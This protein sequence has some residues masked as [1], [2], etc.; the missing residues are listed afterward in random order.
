[1]R[2]GLLLEEFNLPAES[3]IQTTRLRLIPGTSMLWHAERED[4]SR[5]AELLG[6]RVPETWPPPIVPDPSDGGWWS[7]YFLARESSA[8]EWVLI[9]LAGLKGWPSVNESVQMG[10]SFLPEFRDMGYGT[11]GVGALTRWALTQ[12]NVKRVFAEIVIENKAA[13]VVLERV[14]YVKVGAGSED[15]LVRFKCE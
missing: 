5:F 12:P 7:W 11:E 10:C 14:G 2:T 4:K 6:A 15:S 13:H 8:Q 3:R 9:G 1:V